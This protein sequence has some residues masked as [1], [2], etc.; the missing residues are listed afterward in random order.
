MLAQDAASETTTAQSI[1]DETQ[2]IQQ[3]IDRLKDIHQSLT[4]KQPA[5]NE[6]QRQIKRFKKKNERRNYK[7]ICK[8]CRKP[9]SN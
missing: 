4:E 5:L 9:L 2:H 1:D 7:A 3:A 6:V 8:I